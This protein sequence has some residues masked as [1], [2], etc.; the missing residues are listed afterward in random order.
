MKQEGEWGGTASHCWA[1]LVA[2][3]HSP[4]LPCARRRSYILYF[5][6]RVLIVGCVVGPSAVGPGPL[7]PST[8]SWC[9]NEWRLC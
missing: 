6:F 9:A 5:L 2:G 7:V 1:R 3:W 8:C 4:V